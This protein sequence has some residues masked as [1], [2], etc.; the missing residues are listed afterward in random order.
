MN[1]ADELHVLV[2]ILNNYR[3]WISRAIDEE[4]GASERGGGGRDESATDEA[5][6]LRPVARVYGA[7]MQN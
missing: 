2:S 4:S 3:R 7:P 1:E 6:E 5:D